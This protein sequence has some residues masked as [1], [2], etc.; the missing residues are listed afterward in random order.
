MLSDGRFE[1]AE[2]SYACPAAD[3]KGVPAVSC[4]FCHCCDLGGHDCCT[5]WRSSTRTNTGALQATLMRSLQSRLLKGEGEGTGPSPPGAVSVLMPAGAA[6]AAAAA[7]GEQQAQQAQE[8][9]AQ[10]AQHGQPQQDAQQGS[11]QQQQQQA[12]PPFQAEVC[13]RVPGP[14]PTQSIAAA[15]FGGRAASAS[16]A[17]PSAATSS[18]CSMMEG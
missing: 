12:A 16:P 2:P 6:V 9:L 14:P 7:A 8:Q 5:Q 11:K 18:V 3:S 10:Q 17:A 1:S 13:S 15:G 4:G